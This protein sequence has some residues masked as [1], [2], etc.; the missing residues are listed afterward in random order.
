[1]TIPPPRRGNSSWRPQPAEA[2]ERRPAFTQRKPERVEPEPDALESFSIVWDGW[3]LIHNSNR[4]EEMPEFELYNHVDDPLNLKN[5][6]Q[7][8]SDIVEQ[9]TAKIEDWKAR[10][11]KAALPEGDDTEMSAEDLERLAESR[12]HPVNC[13]DPS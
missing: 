8:H 7:E 4:P 2:G 12:I 10:A 9:L 13:L 5:I 6:V 11:L 1:M 3:K